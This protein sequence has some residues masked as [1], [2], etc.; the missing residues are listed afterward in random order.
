MT[1]ISTQ[2]RNAVHAL[3]DFV[4]EHPGSGASDHIRPVL[5][6]LAFNVPV[7]VNLAQMA[8]SLDERNMGNVLAAI[9]TRAFQT[10]PSYYISDDELNGWHEL[11]A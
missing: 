1:D 7:T 4:R 9:R 8:S 2:F 6:S 3:I 5:R 10:W 11:A